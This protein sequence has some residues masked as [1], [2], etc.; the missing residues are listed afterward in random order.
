MTKK[1]LILDLKQ[2][3][4][5]LRRDIINIVYNAKSGHPGGSLSEIDVLVALYHHKLIIDAKNPKWEDRDRFVLSKGHASP[6]FYAVLASK[7]YFPKSELDGFRKSNRMLQGHPELNTP[8]VDFAGG[9]L[10]QGI[11]FAI[12][13][14]LALK[15]DKKDSKVYVMIGDGESQEGAVWEASMAAPFHK[16]ENLI[17]ILDKNQ[18]Q[19]TGKIKE[20]MDLGDVVAKWKAFGWNVIEING[21]D[22]EKVVKA[23]DNASENK[24]GKPTMI[25]SNTIKG[26]GVSFMELNHKFHGKAPNDEE[27]KKAMDELENIDVKTFK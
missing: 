2:K 26:K 13:I 11:C 9:S 3:A 5:E 27:Y 12:G 1:D 8:G 16:L 22:M 17:V 6:G 25:I 24:N 23:L 18:V 20:V 15:L 4:K 10:G 7:G 19:E 14:A 21:H